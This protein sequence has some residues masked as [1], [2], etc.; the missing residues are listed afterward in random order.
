MLREE[1]FRLRRTQSR[2]SMVVLPGCDPTDRQCV[3][4]QLPRAIADA[5]GWWRCRS[6]N[7]AADDD[8][9]SL[10]DATRLQH[11]YQ[12]L[13]SSM[14]CS[15]QADTKSASL[16]SNPSP[17]A[18]LLRDLQDIVNS[19]AACG[20]S[21]GYPRTRYRRPL[22][23]TNDWKAEIAISLQRRAIGGIR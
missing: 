8:L 19:M 12:A 3:V 17:P 23:G 16:G 15:G 2:A 22:L 9:G 13:T 6:A 18:N 7:R 11:R 21:P 14:G 1:L 20:I 5:P 4:L 10:V